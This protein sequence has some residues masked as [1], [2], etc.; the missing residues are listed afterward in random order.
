MSASRSGGFADHQSFHH[1]LNAPSEEDGRGGG[2]RE[3]E[4]DEEAGERMEDSSS[5]SRFSH[6]SG[7]DIGMPVGGG[8]G[9]RRS[10]RSLTSSYAS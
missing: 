9:A 1:H 2:G 8:V 5:V 10:A 6:G 7:S 4:R 3:R